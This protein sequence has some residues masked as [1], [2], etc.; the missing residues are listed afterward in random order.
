M[1]ERSTQDKKKRVS[2]A[3][4]PQVTYIYPEE[5]QDGRSGGSGTMSEDEVSMELTMD[6][7]RLQGLR[8]VGGDGEGNTGAKFLD[9][10]L[11]RLMERENPGNTSARGVCDGEGISALE[12]GDKARHRVGHVDGDQSECTQIEIPDTDVTMSSRCVSVYGDSVEGGE[13]NGWPGC[14]RDVGDTVM[15]NDT[16]NV[17]EII[18]TQDLRKMIPQA[19]REGVGVCELLVSK[20]IRFLDNLVVSNTRRDTMSKSRN[21]VDPQQIQF[22]ENFVEPR[23]QFFLDFSSELEERMSRQEEIN[24]ELEKRFSSVGTVFEQEDAGS[25][26]K[27]LKAEC[28]SRAK[29]EWYLLRKEREVEFNRMVVDRK[30]RLVSEYNGLVAR[31]QEMEEVVRQKEESSSR[32]MEQ[33]CRMRNRI[34][35]MKRGLEK[36]GTEFR[37]E[38][39]CQRISELRG[40]VGKQEELGENVRKEVLELG[41]EK[42][43]LEGERRALEESLF[44]VSR[45]IKELEAALE[46]RGATE[47]Q[48]K[49]AR[50]EFRT[51]CAVLDWEIVRVERERVIVRLLGYEF[52]IELSGEQTITSIGVDVVGSVRDHPLY[53][54]SRKWF[55]G[56]GHTFF[57]GMEEIVF[58]A[59][60]VSGIHKELGEIRNKHG[61]VW[62]VEE[63]RVVARITLVNPSK[64]VRKD[65]MV[66]IRDGFRN[67]VI[68]DGDPVHDLTSDLGVISRSIHSL[69]SAL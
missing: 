37:V 31:V 67:C 44:D 64:R 30:N 11:D 22:Y 38:E 24:K 49:E 68:G 45:E 50:Q 12:A 60:V 40:M 47:A 62:D 36:D 34:N 66:T 69:Y 53:T 48:V 9:V 5:N 21:T 55:G 51:L 29:I 27:A 18:S 35:E 57:R 43:D 32:Q 15:S 56:V 8:T 4:E 63:D 52:S 13:V 3:P 41:R 61:L 10:D 1:D 46:T 42:M 28:R 20:G 33:I 6:H 23:T 25:V 7:T 39:I 14:G 19:R 17:E 2:F 65:V 58:L 16:V 26:L 54:Y 59:S